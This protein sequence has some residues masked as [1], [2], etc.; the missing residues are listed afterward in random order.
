MEK[1]S[2]L[3]L[4]F[5]AAA[6]LCTL[7]NPWTGWYGLVMIVVAGAAWYTERKLIRR[8][9]R[10]AQVHAMAKKMSRK[11][12]EA[13]AKADGREEKSLRSL[14]LMMVPMLMGADALLT[15]Y[16]CFY[17]LQKQR[18]AAVFAWNCPEGAAWALCLAAAFLLAGS[19]WL[20]WVHA[21]DL[22]KETL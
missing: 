11:Q 16:T 6:I 3:W 4:L 7:I 2:R 20:F 12:R 8:N 10:N 1:L 22:L 17:N 18:M 5:A 13:Y 15:V 19:A 14:A 21:K 9:A